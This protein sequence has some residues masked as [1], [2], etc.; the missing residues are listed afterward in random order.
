MGNPEQDKKIGGKPTG[1]LL[2]HDGYA[3]GGCGGRF[4]ATPPD[5]PSTGARLPPR[6]RGVGGVG[7]S[8]GVRTGNTQKPINLRAG[9]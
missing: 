5:Y 3:V 4:A 9:T 7:H 1:N 8:A 6:N 2:P